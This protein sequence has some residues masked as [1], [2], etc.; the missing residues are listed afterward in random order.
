MWFKVDFHSGI[1][2]YRQI[3]NRMI[4]AIARGKLDDKTAMPSIRELAIALGVNPNTV[5][6]AYRELE[7]LGYIYSR[8]GIGMFVNVRRDEIEGM[9][10]REIEDKLKAIL[11]SAVKRGISL[12]KCREV[13]DKCVEEV[14]DERSDTCC[15]SSQDL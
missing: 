15:G 8:P 6:K 1:P 4:E 7:H 14:E 5:A 9:I 3:V 11:N 12:D 2:A 10:L 13:F